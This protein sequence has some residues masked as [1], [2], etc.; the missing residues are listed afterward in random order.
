MDVVENNS[1]VLVQICS[2][3]GEATGPPLDVPLSLNIKQLQLLCNSLLENVRIH[4]VHC[5]SLEM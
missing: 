4:V 2:E 1:S 5:Y 3:D